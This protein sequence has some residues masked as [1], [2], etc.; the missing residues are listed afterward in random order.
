MLRI[1]HAAEPP[2]YSAD[3]VVLPAPLVAAYGAAKAHQSNKN[4]AET[5]TPNAIKP[6]TNWTCP[7][8]SNKDQDTIGWR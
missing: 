7:Q 2:L 1:D 3:S 8:V 6:L 4:N 5:N